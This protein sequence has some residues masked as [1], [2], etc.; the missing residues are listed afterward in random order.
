MG[1]S[2]DV[3]RMTREA[4]HAVWAGSLMLGV[5]KVAQ[6]QEASRLRVAV[7][8]TSASSAA[9]SDPSFAVRDS[10]RRHP[11]LKGAGIGALVGAA[12]GLAYGVYLNANSKCSLPAGLECSHEEDALAYILL[13][14]YGAFFGSIGG[15]LVGV[16][17]R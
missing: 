7:H 12:V 17:V 11:I 5:A 6:G 2:M 3:R 9:L 16:I 4:R 13:P 10:T 14:A 15:A 8:A 1:L